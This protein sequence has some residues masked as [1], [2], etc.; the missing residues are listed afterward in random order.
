MGALCSSGI[1]SHMPAGTM[2]PPEG[3]VGAREN[4]KIIKKITEQ[5]LVIA[6]HVVISAL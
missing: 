3:F 5:S 2:G 6:K 1:G 4:L